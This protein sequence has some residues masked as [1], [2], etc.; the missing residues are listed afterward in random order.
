MSCASRALAAGSCSLRR[1]AACAAS[2]TWN[3]RRTRSRP[4]T[5]PPGSRCSTCRSG[6]CR[7][8]TTRRRSARSATATTADERNMFMEQD[9]GAAEPDGLAEIE[10][11]VEVLIPRAERREWD[12][13]ERERVGDELKEVRRERYVQEPLSY[14]GKLEFTALLGETL[15]AI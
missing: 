12:I 4:A 10:D 7:E 13:V 11:V 9:G 3:V 8:R 1:R 14:F 2:G 15:D 6:H 5:C